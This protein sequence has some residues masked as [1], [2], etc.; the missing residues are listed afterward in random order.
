MLTSARGTLFEPGAR[1]HAAQHEGDLGREV[2][3]HDIG[4]NEKTGTGGGLDSRIFRVSSFWQ[5]NQQL[6]GK[7]KIEVQNLE[8]ENPFAWQPRGCDDLYALEAAGKLD[9]LLEDAT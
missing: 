4:G 2:D 9:W 1:C 3:A 5:P 6:S 8:R 7:L